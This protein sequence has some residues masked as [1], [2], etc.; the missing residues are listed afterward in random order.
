MPTDPGHIHSF[1]LKVITWNRDSS[2][3]CG[4]ITQVNIVRDKYKKSHGF[5]LIELVLVMGII[6]LFSSLIFS[7][8][9]IINTSH[10]RVAVT[11]D[12][13]DFASLNMQ[14]IS[15]LVINADSVILSNSSTAQSGYT[16]VYFTSASELFY[17]PFGIATIPAFSY[18]QYHID[19]LAKDVKWRVIPTYTFG[20][21]GTLDV[22]L[23]IIDNSTSNI[24][25]TLNQS[26]YLPNAVPTD[27]I[28]NAGGTAN[29]L[30][31]RNPSYI[32]I[33]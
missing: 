10:A 3:K 23:Q 19:N 21:S 27:M 11:N 31:F 25:Y 26:F 9:L 1:V 8:F 33:S 28:D 4:R 5:T 7:T 14:A 13:K 16:V 18:P 2:G 29:V 30:K 22:K 17:T 15:N 20:A 12:A 32:S 24:F 6:V